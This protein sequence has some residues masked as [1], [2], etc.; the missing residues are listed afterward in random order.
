MIPAIL[1]ALAFSVYELFFC[2]M[3]SFYLVLILPFMPGF[4]LSERI[5]CSVVC[6][7]VT[8]HHHL[9]NLPPDVAARLAGRS[10]AAPPAPNTWLVAAATRTLATPS[11]TIPDPKTTTSSSSSSSKSGAASSTSQEDRDGLSSSN[12]TI[13]AGSQG[14]ASWLYLDGSQKGEVLD[15]AACL[16]RYPNMKVLEASPAAAAVRYWEPLDPKLDN[17]VSEASSS[18][19]DSSSSGSSA[20]VALLTLLR[21][22]ESRWRVEQHELGRD[23][24]EVWA[25]LARTV[26]LAHQRRG[27]SDYVAHWLYLLMALDTTAPEWGHVLADL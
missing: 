15:A 2:A 24:M 23:V 1:C 3:S 26:V 27:E 8:G 14:T 17:G 5:A 10:L 18:V 21:K 20:G 7:A 6:N 13:A 4:K 25:E 22:G 16:E 11:F 19:G 9:Q 12:S